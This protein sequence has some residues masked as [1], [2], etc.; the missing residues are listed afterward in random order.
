MTMRVPLVA[1][2]HLRPLEA[3]DAPEL[4]D[5]YLRNRE[6][7]RR[8]DPE[9]PDSYWTLEGQQSRLNAQLEQQQAGTLLATAMLRDERI[10]GCATLQTIVR[11]A[12]SSASLGYWVD[13][14][15][16]GQGLASAATDA[17]CRIADQE[18]GLHRISASTSPANLASQ[19]VLAKNGFEQFGL[20]PNYLH[21]NGRWQD[22]ALFQ[23]ILNDRP[24]SP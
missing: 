22:S 2:V 11:G 7:L 15:E 24:P 10:L 18:L 3:S 5:A 1:G 16:L 20:A 13:V 14:D 6:H 8:F 23:R 4:L 21:I 19:R 12:L 9:R 17:L